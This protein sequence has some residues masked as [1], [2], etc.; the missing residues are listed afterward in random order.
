MTGLPCCSAVLC[1]PKRRPLRRHA[2]ARRRDFAAPRP[3]T[4][5]LVEMGRLVLWMAVV[6]FGAAAGYGA[7][8]ARL[9]PDNTIL[10]SAC[11]GAHVFGA[12]HFQSRNSE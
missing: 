10:W 6:G 4:F 2:L 7:K 3:N 1:M 12:Q 5:W 9:R 8:H 11:V